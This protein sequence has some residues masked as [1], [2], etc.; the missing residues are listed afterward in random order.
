MIKVQAQP[1][2]QA[3]TQA[4]AVLQAIPRVRELREVV[5]QCHA[6][7]CAPFMP[8][9]RSHLYFTTEERTYFVE[10]INEDEVKIMWYPGV[11]SRFEEVRTVSMQINLRNPHDV[12]WLVS[13]GLVEPLVSALRARIELIKVW[14]RELNG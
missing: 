13:N 5:R 10:V 2:Q 3:Q 14:E 9:L 7:N 6:I 11:V 4:Q 12:I 1:N 8:D